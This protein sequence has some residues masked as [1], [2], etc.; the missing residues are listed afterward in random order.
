MP[1][2]RDPQC[3]ESSFRD[4]PYRARDDRLAAVGARAGGEAEG[5]A[6]KIVSGAVA[7]LAALLDREQEL[8]HRA[9]EAAGEPGAGQARAGDAAGGAEGDGLLV[10]TRAVTRERALGADDER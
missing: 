3:I 8:G 1:A 7:G 5:E 4:A 6:L 10:E 2:S 9:V